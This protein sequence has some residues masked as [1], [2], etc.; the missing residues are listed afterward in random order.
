[1]KK[2]VLILTLLLSVGFIATS[3]FAMP[4]KAGEWE[5]QLKNWELLGLPVPN[6]DFDGDGTKDD[7]LTT[8]GD[9]SYI[10]SLDTTGDG[11][12]DVF[13]DSLGIFFVSNIGERGGSNY[14]SSGGDDEITGVFHSVDIQRYNDYLDT[15]DPLSP[16]QMT[17]VESVGGIIDIYYDTNANFDEFDPSTATDGTPVLQ[18]EMVPGIRPAGDATQNGN[19]EGT[20]VPATGSAAAYLSVVIGSGLPWESFFDTNGFD[21]TWTPDGGSLTAGVADAFMQTSYY[22]FT[23]QQAPSYT[24]TEL[25]DAW[26]NGGLFSTDPIVG[27]T[28]PEPTTMLLL[29]SG[30]LGLAALGRKRFKKD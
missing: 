16:T 13:G 8:N 10:H 5:L 19:L 27:A 18:L 9:G 22:P 6:H 17:Y 26:F 3:V 23:S 28:I 4:F 1:M 30:L 21:V 11:S 2:K 12:K 24:S 7:Y 25:A 14:W 20:S 15:S 29:G